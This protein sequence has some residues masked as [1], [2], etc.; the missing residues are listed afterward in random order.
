MSTSEQK[1]E[2]LKE[3]IALLLNKAENTNFPAEAQTFQEHAERLMVRYGI[4]RA[5]LDAQ[6]AHG[7]KKEPILEAHFDMRGT[8][9]L[10]QRDGLSVVGHA[11]RTVTLLQT[12]YSNFCRLYIIG[13][14]SDVATVK[15]LF[16]SLVIQAS[17]AMSHWWSIEGKHIAWD[18]TGS[19]KVIERREFQR[20]FYLQVAERIHGL[21]QEES[22]HNG[23][24]TELVL[25]SRKE[26]VDDFVSEKYPSLRRSR[27][28]AASGSINA[29]YA[30]R[31]A[32]SRADLGFGK[33]V[34]GR[35]TAGEV[36]S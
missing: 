4:G 17:L 24:G 3:R 14:E 23:S 22:E 28:R 27:N 11:F 33:D 2:R 15:N 35:G 16:S 29:A 7:K 21:Y 31:V 18:R 25:V 30:G 6:P 5:E 1:L 12:N 13:H 20:S 8:Y 9:R 26:Q 36:A 10:G 19:E 34:E 32:G